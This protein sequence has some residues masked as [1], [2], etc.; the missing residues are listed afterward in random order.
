MK[1]LFIKAKYI[2]DTLLLPGTLDPMKRAHPD[3]E[4]RVVMRAGVA[5]ILAGCSA[6]DGGLSFSKDKSLKAD[7]ALIRQ[8]RA[9]KF[10]LAFEPG[11]NVLCRILALLNGAQ[12]ILVQPGGSPRVRFTGGRPDWRSMAGLLYSCVA[13]GGADTP[14]VHLAQWSPTGNAVR[15]VTADPGENSI[16]DIPVS[17]VM[18]TFNSL[19]PLR[20]HV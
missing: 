16:A 1:H 14:A 6:I 10:D 2:G 15:I 11:G 9:M 20:D 4:T 18:E 12:S 8:I 7:F 5:G 3:A 13:H 19:F 17:R